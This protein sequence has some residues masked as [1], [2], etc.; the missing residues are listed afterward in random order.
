MYIV[1]VANHHNTEIKSRAANTINEARVILL[2]AFLEALKARDTILGEDGFPEP[3]KA[4]ETFECFYDGVAMELKE[5]KFAI[6]ADGDLSFGVLSEI[7]G[8][9]RPVCA[10]DGYQAVLILQLNRIRGLPGLDGSEFWSSSHRIPVTSE[11]LAEID[12]GGDHALKALLLKRIQG[13]LA[14]RRGWEAIKQACKDYNWGDCVMDNFDSACHCIPEDEACYLPVRVCDLNVNQDEH[15]APTNVCISW[16]CYAEG[17][18][19]PVITDFCATLDMITG[20]VT[21]SEHAE[22]LLDQALNG[23]LSYDHATNA[24]VAKDMAGPESVPVKLTSA[25]ICFETKGDMVACEKENDFLYL[26]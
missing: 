20:E 21:L 5:N 13:E 22:A 16:F 6:E 18:E 26:A 10:A 23:E 24:L 25:S 4:G 11:E 15:I 1:S 8:E 17:V 12:E 3:P 2:D 7:P 14:S 19:M 9:F